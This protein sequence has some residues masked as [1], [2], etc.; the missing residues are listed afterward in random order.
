MSADLTQVREAIGRCRALRDKGVVEAVL[1]GEFQSRL[2]RIFPD[3]EDES[4]I[5]HYGEGAEAHTKVGI[6]GGAAANRFIDNLIGSTTIEYE[7]DLRIPAKRDEGFG[8][9]K[10]HAAG[11][12]RRGVPVSQVR[13]I[14]SDTVDWYAYDVKLDPGADP[15]SCSVEDVELVEVE[16]FEPATDDEPTAERLTLFLRRHLAREQSRPLIADNLAF[17]LGLESPA[18]RRNV[19]ALTGLV[20]TGREEDPSIALATDLWS[21]FV[22]H[23]EG[24]GGAFRIGPYVDEVYL[25]I[26]ARLLSANALA[27]TAIV[28]VDAELQAI[29]NGSFF[30]DT[31]Q[32]DNLVEKDYFGWIAQPA[33]V[34]G[35]L[36]VAR[37]IQRDLYAYD[38]SWRAE[39]DLFGRLM[40]QLARRS[41][42]KLLG[43]EWTPSWLARHLAERCLD[44]LP[45]GE[46][47]EIVDMCCGSG[48]ML[49]EV[50]KA[51]KERYR[52]ND[53]VDLGNVATGFDID[54]LAVAF[55]KTTWVI[56]LADEINAAAAPV[57]IPVFHA[58]SLF[59]VTPVSASLPMLGEGDAIDITLDG[60]T[61][62]LPVGLLQPEYRELFGGLVDWAYD[63]AHEDGGVPPT[64]ENARA[65]L[66]TVAADSHVTLSAELRD[67]AAEA[68]LALARRMKELADVGR[69]G[70]WAF[71]LRNTYRP[72]LLAGQ[73]N[74]LVSN[75][76]WLAMSALADNPYR[77]MLSRR[78]ALYG[79]RPAGQSFLHLELGTT[80]LLHAVDRYLK[81]DAAVACLVPGTILN[82]NH[83]ERFRQ[84]GFIGSDRPVALSVTEVWQVPPGTFKYPGAALIGKKEDSAADADN[85]V[86]TGAVARPDEVEAVDLVIRKIGDA[87]TAWVLESGGM[88][89]AAAGGD[90]V[91]RQGAD[92]MP[93]SAVCIE[94]LNSSGQEYRVNS[95]RPGTEWG[96][97]IKQAKELKGERFPGYV[98]PRFI[99]RMAQ[100]ENLLP[101]VFGPH[102][103][104]VAIP[105]C[106]DAH[107]TWQR[108]K[109]AD[110]RRMGFTRTAR[111]F[112]EI[113]DKLATIGDSTLAYRIDFRRKLTIQDFGDE[114]F[115]VLSGAGGKHICAACLP[116]A[117]ASELVI[118]QTLYWQVVSS[119]ADAWFRIGI[120]NSAA[121][122]EA[123][124]PFNPEGDFG[125][126]HIHTLPYR[127][128]PPYDP[129]N[130]DHRAVVS[131]AQ[132]VAEEAAAIV[133]GDAYIG[134]PDRSLPVRRRKLREKLADGE[135]FQELDRLCASILGTG[136]ASAEVNGEDAP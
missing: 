41:Q 90:E 74:G 72:G 9:V 132:S 80:H 22:D 126:R 73:F 8:Q 105:A 45:E 51:V 21:H 123:I 78:A 40:A 31:Y 32:L 14:L 104:P 36:P 81:P 53:I 34:A 98:A 130:D 100:S 99:H 107:G 128:M 97:T 11:L 68:V 117:E 127:L 61:V 131:A 92:I 114:G 125:P 77:E 133:A 103:A 96:F 82:G 91:S 25:N 44:D 60:E 4:W 47:P 48:A 39:E 124:L 56:T 113:D 136:V 83:H 12:I 84:R 23:L 102:R 59:A 134:D 28:S 26:L 79:V 62:Q 1:R 69:N 55:A 7:A 19:D 46:A 71:I 106:R 108:Y 129:A 119:E 63:E 13:G 6:A 64:L 95:P 66:D 16:R 120:L 88:P 110:I 135:S 58:D 10:E 20:E 116:V 29:L 86:A 115:V 70:I 3:P 54:P 101:F 76:P 118:D 24:E 33:H 15:G 27:G 75:P 42:R 30:R 49:A 89:A 112:A 109:P 17:D 37:E 52:H 122:T 50:I 2:R 111:R 85:A 38:F 93:R 35:F 121:L 43:Q 57:T 5:N 18:Y 94:I 67:A 65:T 87:R